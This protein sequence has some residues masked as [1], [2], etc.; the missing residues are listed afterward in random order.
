MGNNLG[1]AIGAVVVII[2]AVFLIFWQVSGGKKTGTV[3]Q[4]AVKQANAESSAALE[5]LTPAMELAAK[6]G[7]NATGKYWATN[8][9]NTAM[10]RRLA[11]VFGDKLEDAQIVLKGDVSRDGESGMQ[12]CIFSYN[13]KNYAFYLVKDKRGNYKLKDFGAW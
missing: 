2:L 3:N 9:L 6:S 12:C 11:G 1:K 4:E 8:S 10:K 13:G 5:V 7:W